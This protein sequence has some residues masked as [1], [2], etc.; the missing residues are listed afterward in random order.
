MPKKYSI[1][2][3]LIA[4][5]FAGLTVSADQLTRGEVMGRWASPGSIFEIFEVDGILHGKIIAL[6]DS[7]YTEEEAAA[8]AG[9][10]RLDDNNPDE[11]LRIRQILGLDIFLNYH[12]E[13]AQWAG[14]IYDPEPGNT[15]KSKLRVEKGLL[16]I[17]GYIGLP[18]FG[19]TSKFPSASTCLDYIR[20]ML[21]VAGES[22][23]C[24]GTAGGGN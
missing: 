7:V 22:S 6:K 23:S 2:P 20:E 19:R 24:T 18:M 11:S 17:R 9:Q 16:E 5:L 1:P 3:L 13:D 12:F 4:F 14:N 8:K 21:L 15:Y 10:V